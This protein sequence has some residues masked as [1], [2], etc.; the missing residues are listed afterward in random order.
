MNPAKR[1]FTKQLLIDAGIREGMRVLDVG[2]GT[3]DV[4]F[5]LSTL[6]GET[7]E[8]VGVD[9]DDNALA[10]ARKR[11]ASAKYPVPNFIQSGL[12]NL[13]ESI[14]M[15]DAIV[16]R[17]VLMY[18]A[19]TVATVSALVKHLHPG[20]VMVFQEHDTTMVPASIDAFPLHRTAQGWIQQMIAREGADL[21]IGFNLHGIFTTAG[22]CVADVRAECVVQ[23][24]DTPYG[25]SYIVLACLPR[26]VALGVATPDEVNIETL[27]QRLDDE[28]SQSGGIYVGDVMFGAWAYKPGQS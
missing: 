10:T 14:G 23:T 5:L 15:F 12:L 6:V 20:G 16:G 26:I 28:R 4:S 17:R 13:T 11:E 8:V 24:P 19:D 22:L 2:C 25:L 7:G 21:H 1:D 9:H 18:Q 27:E 3:G